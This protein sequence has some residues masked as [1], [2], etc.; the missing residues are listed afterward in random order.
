MNKKLS[1]TLFLAVFSVTL[2]VGLVVPLLPVYAYELGATG[3]YIGFIFGAFSLSRTV[4]LPY[5]GHL[6]DLKGRKPFITTGLLA[7]FLV[8]IA[9]VL[10]KDVNFFIAIRF[11]QGIASAMILPV[12]QAY[13][14]EITPSWHTVLFF[15]HGSG[16]FGRL[17]SVPHLSAAESP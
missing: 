13:V 15:E 8:S 2:G 1:S 9:Y 4:F 10:S 3:L 14:G 5:F 12:A 16:F 7:Y 17:S 6:S 11:F